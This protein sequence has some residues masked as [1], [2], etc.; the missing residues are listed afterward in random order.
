[1]THF[2]RPADGHGLAHDPFNAI[3][4]PRPIGWISSLA[5]NGTRNLAPYSFFNAFNYRPPIVGFCSIGR[6]D[7]VTNLEATGEF[8]WNL[9]T[10]DLAE[11]MNRTAT[12]DRVDEWERAGVTAADS[13]V[14]APQRVADSPVAFECRVTQVVQ[15]RDQHGGEIDAWMTFGEVVGVHIDERFLVDGVYDTAAARPVMRA[16][17]PSAYY[18]VGERFDL[19]RPD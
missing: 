18:E 16:G 5:V 9:V 10:R 1:M 7:S 12:A 3:V 6:K 2:Y 8:V 15:L 11:A 17:G 19:R 4:A 14:V 13:T